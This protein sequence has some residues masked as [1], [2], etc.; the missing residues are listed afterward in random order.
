ERGASVTEIG[1]Q[2]NGLNSNDGVGAMHVEAVSAAVVEHG[3]DLGIAVDGD[4]DR[5]VMVDSSGRNCNGDEL[6]YAIVRERLD[7]GP[8]QGVVGTLMTNFAFE[9]KMAEHGIA[10]TRAAVGDRHVLEAMLERGW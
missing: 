8:V 1:C 10:F 9:R 6:L 7:H 3:A 4:A 2:P 5:L